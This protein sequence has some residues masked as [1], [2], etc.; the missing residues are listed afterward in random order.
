ML[1]NI[2]K[3]H[4]EF[5]EYLEIEKGRSLKTIENYDRYLNRFWEYSKIEFPSEITDETVRGFR[6]WLNRQK[7]AS[8]AEI[9]KKTQNYYLIALRCFLKYLIKRNI[10]ALTPEAIELAKISER[11]L[12]L[13]SDKDLEL[14]LSSASLKDLKS[15]RDKAILELFFSTGLRVSELCFLKI[16]NI[17]LKK[18]EFSIKGKGDKIRV[19]FLS[20]NAKKSLKEYLDRRTDMNEALFMRIPKNGKMPDLNNLNKDSNLT[21]RS[22]QR[23]IKY[24]AAKA[25]ITGKLTPHTLR[26]MFATDLLQNGADIRSVQSM[27][28]HKNITTTQIYTHV[29]D[30]YLKEIHKKFH[31]KKGN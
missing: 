9:K 25:G 20:D 17:N 21:P 19:V 30:K 12:D 6:L 8:G 7:T 16:S 26:H 15:L 2:T 10:K 24:Y 4:R 29:S 31:N 5:L 28:G 23:I 27:L 18:D 11:Q 13:I 14:L 22:V 3:F 1:N